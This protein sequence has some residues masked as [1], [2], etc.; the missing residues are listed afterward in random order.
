MTIKRVLSA[1]GFTV[2]L[3]S[4]LLHGQAPASIAG[5]GFLQKVTSGTFP[6]A[7][8]GYYLLLPANTGSSYQ[9]RTIYNSADSSGTYTY[10]LTGP[11]SAT[12]GCTDPYVGSVTFY[13]YF[14]S[15]N[16]GTFSALVSTFPGAYQNGYFNFASS[17]APASLAGKR[18]VAAIND[19]LSPFGSAGSFEFRAAASGNAYVIIGDGISTPNSAGTYTYS[20]ANRCTGRLQVTD[21]IT[22]VST[23]YIGLTDTTNGGYAITQPSGGFQ[24]GSFRLLDT[25]PPTVSISSPPGARTYTN[26]QS[27]DIVVIANDDVGVVNVEFY[28]GAILKGAVATAPYINNWSFTSA[29][30]GTHNW[31][32]RAYDAA[33]NVKTSAVVTLNVSIDV[34][35]PT[36]S[37]TTPTNGQNVATAALTFSGTAADPGSP[38]S[39][40]SRVELRLNGGSWTNASGTTNWTRTLTLSPCTNTIE[41]RSRD[42]AGNYSSISSRTFFYSPANTPPAKPVNISP[43]SGAQ[44]MGI[45][46][47]LQA[48]AFSDSDCLGDTH[49]ASQWQVLSAGGSVIVADS[50]T[51]SVSLTRWVVPANKLYYGSNYQ[52]RVRYRDSRNGWS[53]YSTQTRFTNGGPI[54]V[55]SKQGSNIVLNWPTNAPGFTL[56]WSTDLASPIWSNTTPAPV[57][58][59]GQYAVTNGTTNNSR[60]YRL[61]K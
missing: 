18:F 57:I 25:T 60:F 61:K 20:L 8:F 41:A 15:V 21:S 14:A 29:D 51:N 23:V 46:P 9:V 54:L 17:P 50:G 32:A 40:L 33:G 47:T 7:P 2:F 38:S 53:T 10:F 27:V 19:G 5:K 56:Q 36:I 16:S 35:P 4:N 59:S 58:V 30:N 42:K 34:T 1:V 28:D 13:A 45:T 49:L 22:G 11:S 6:F 26:A 3:S 31:T 43:A 39:A 24:V 12:L 52:W 48:N 55:S 44:N 37:I